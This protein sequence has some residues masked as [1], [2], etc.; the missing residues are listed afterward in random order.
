MSS[1]SPD[2]APSEQAQKQDFGEGTGR[3]GSEPPFFPRLMS[4]INY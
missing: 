2:M 1:F 4:C 3:L